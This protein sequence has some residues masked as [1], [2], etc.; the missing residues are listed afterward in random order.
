MRAQSHAIARMRTLNMLQQK[1]GR[2]MHLCPLQF[3]IVERAIE[4][5]TMPGETVFDPF[6][7]IMTVPYC[8]LSMGRKAVATELNPDYFAD[9]CT[10]AEMAAGGVTGPALFDLLEAEAFA[11]DE[12][13]KALTAEAMPGTRAAF[14]DEIEAVCRR[15]NLSIAHED[16]EGGFEIEPFSTDN[17]AWLREAGAFEKLEAAE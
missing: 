7:G 1:K 4:D 8:A 9:G 12:V 3:D 15:H 6:G 10:Y 17:M 11:G 2:E 13:R 5:Y 16:R 14:L